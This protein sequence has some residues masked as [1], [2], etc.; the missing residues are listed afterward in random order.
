MVKAGKTRRRSSTDT[1]EFLEKLVELCTKNGVKRI[2]VGHPKPICIEFKES[3]VRH[4]SLDEETRKD[5]MFKEE[6]DKLTNELDEKLLMNPMEYEAIMSS[7]EMEATLDEPD[8]EE[9]DE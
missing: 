8:D 5:V 3:Y 9:I 7:G 1:F 4:G 6:T 2:E